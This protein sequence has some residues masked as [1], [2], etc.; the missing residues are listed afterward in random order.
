MVTAPV[1]CTTAAFTRYPKKHPCPMLSA[2]GSLHIR[3]TSI[4]IRNQS[5]PYAYLYPRLSVF[6]SESDRKCENKYN[7]NG[8]RPY[9]IRLHP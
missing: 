7:I 4:R 9:Q 3:Y 8:I 1:I 6:E 5:N 2:S